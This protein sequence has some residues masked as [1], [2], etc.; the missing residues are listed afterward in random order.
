MRG[1]VGAESRTDPAAPCVL[2]GE[3]PALSVRVAE[4]RNRVSGQK[5]TAGEERLHADLVRTAKG[6]ELE[7]WK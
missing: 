1:K 2:G 5:F 3:G 7:T 4:E 6:R